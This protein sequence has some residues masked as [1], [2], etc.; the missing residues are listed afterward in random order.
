[1]INFHLRICIRSNPKSAA[2]YI[3]EQIFAPLTLVGIGSAWASGVSVFKRQGFFSTLK[4]KFH[5]RVK[6]T[7]SKVCRES[8]KFPDLWICDLFK[9][10]HWSQFYLQPIGKD[11]GFTYCFKWGVLCLTSSY[12]QNNVCSSLLNQRLMNDPAGYSSVV[13]LMCKLW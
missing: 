5:L 9:Y 12:L 8:S 7:N 4:V 3:H 1:M 13:V 10:H 11:A 2:D 6:N